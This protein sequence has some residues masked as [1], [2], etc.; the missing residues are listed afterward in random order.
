MIIIIA[1]TR[2]MHRRPQQAIACCLE[3]RAPATDLLS[4][5]CTLLCLL[6][7]SRRCGPDAAAYMPAAEYSLLSTSGS[8]QHSRYIQSTSRLCYPTMHTAQ[9][10]SLP[11]TTHNACGKPT[12]ISLWDRLS[13]KCMRK[14]PTPEAASDNNSNPCALHYMFL[15]DVACWV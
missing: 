11:A 4:L 2:Q 6:P 9:M 14:Q 7:I 15:D 5:S 8:R 3:T 10:V 13:I 12:L 1:H